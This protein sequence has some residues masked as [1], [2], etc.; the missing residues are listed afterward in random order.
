MTE[1]PPAPPKMVP[2]P[3]PALEIRKFEVELVCFPTSSPLQGC[4]RPCT[5]AHGCSQEGT[6]NITHD[7]LFS[8]GSV[9]RHMFST[10]V[11][12]LFPRQYFKTVFFDYNLSQLRASGQGKLKFWRIWRQARFTLWHS[13][14][15]GPVSIGKKIRH[16]W[17]QLKLYIWQVKEWHWYFDNIQKKLT[18][19]LMG[20][21]LG[22]RGGRQR[23]THWHV[24]RAEE[25]L[26]K[27]INTVL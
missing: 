27:N 3:R 15:Q 5:C 13:G 9:R 11:R 20:G 21:L 16:E 23:N 26:K 8:F 17:S 2:A 14:R 7:I 22:I 24:D 12:K 25:E 10:Y 1:D 4:P 19:Q 18:N 6:C